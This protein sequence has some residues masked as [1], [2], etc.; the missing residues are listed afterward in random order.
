MI[1]ISRKTFYEYNKKDMSP[2][3]QKQ[4]IIKK[5]RKPKMSKYEK[6]LFFEKCIEMRNEKVAV[7]TLWARKIIKQITANRWLPSKSAISNLFIKNGWKRRKSQQRNPQSDPPD[8]D[9][10]ISNF[11]KELKDL[12]EQN[13]LKRENVHIMDETGLYSD[14]I[15]PRAKDKEAYVCSSYKKRHDTLPSSLNRE[16]K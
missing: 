11:L 7:T 8:K 10:K 3:Q 2:N 12:I 14:S 6:Q 1:N 15:P 4:R 13:H 5:G 9:K 16:I